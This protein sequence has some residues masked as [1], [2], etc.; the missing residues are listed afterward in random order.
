MAPTLNK[1]VRI[2]FTAFVE[3]SA[4]TTGVP[5]GTSLTVVNG[6]SSGTGW[7]SDSAGNLTITADG[8][9]IS[10]LD[11]QGSVSN[12]THTGFTIDKCRIRCWGEN[13]WGLILAQNCTVQDTEIGGGLDGVTFLRCVLIDS[14]GPNNL[15]Q[16]CNL[17]HTTSGI[18]WDNGTT[19]LAN[20]LHDMVMGD[21]AQ[22]FPTGTTTDDHSSC[23]L[24]TGAVPTDLT[25][26][27]V[28]GNSLSSGNTA[29]L[30]VQ[31]DSTDATKMIGQ[32]TI[33]RNWFHNYHHNGQDS[34]FGVDIENK[35]I[36]GPIVLTNNVFDKTGW[37]VGPAQVPNVNATYSGNKYTD[38]TSADADV[39]VVGPQ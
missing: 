33:D 31:R 26:L 5:V 37:T 18:R 20:Y 7:T 8:A 36:L 6:V 9:V 19:I 35:G 4:A 28:Y 10:G 38:G 25:P 29:N 3:P 13:D 23:M 2:G 34:S 30:F 22:E 14:Y 32:I 11:I 21:P 39:Q 17:H 12:G 15:I 16:R 27:Y 24:C 1:S